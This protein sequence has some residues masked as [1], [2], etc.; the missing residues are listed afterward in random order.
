MTPAVFVFSAFRLDTFWFCEIGPRVIGEGLRMMAC[1][2]KNT[3][4][5]RW[6]SRRSFGARFCPSS[7]EPSGRRR[8]HCR[9]DL[10]RSSLSNSSE[11]R[12]DIRPEKM[13]AAEICREE[14]R[15]PIFSLFVCACA[16]ARRP[17]PFFV[18]RVGISPGCCFETLCGTACVNI[19]GLK[20]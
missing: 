18:L 10:E 7:L 2:A 6:K 9:V 5:R 11:R 17:P 4:V 14:K 3:A 8:C 20:S 16:R 1:G 13:L 12:M 19:R 15:T